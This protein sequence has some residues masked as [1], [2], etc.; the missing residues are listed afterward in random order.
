M[1]KVLRGASA[2]GPAVSPTGGRRHA[3]LYEVCQLSEPALFALVCVMHECFT[4]LITSE[5]PTG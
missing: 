3:C 5:E 2:R 4:L 1:L